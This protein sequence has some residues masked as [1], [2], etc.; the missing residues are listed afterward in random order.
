MLE[1]FCH[2]FLFYFWSLANLLF[3]FIFDRKLA[4]ICTPKL[5][6]KK[7]NGIGLDISKQEPTTNTLTLCDS[8][9]LE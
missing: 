6:L 3:W 9:I 4:G 7:T 1:I 5:K 8:I 2:F